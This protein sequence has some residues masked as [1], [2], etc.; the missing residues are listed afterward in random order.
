MKTFGVTDY[1]ILVPLKCCDGRTDGRTDG[2]M[3]SR[4]DGVDSLLGL[5]RVQQRECY[6]AL[7]VLVSGFTHYE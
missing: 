1:T 4:T 7:I 6:R 2:G 3:D 5:R